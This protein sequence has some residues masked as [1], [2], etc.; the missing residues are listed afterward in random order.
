MSMDTKHPSYNLTIAPEEIKKYLEKK[1]VFI[2]TDDNDIE[3]LAAL[4][5]AEY[6]Y[7]LDQV[8]QERAKLLAVLCKILKYACVWNDYR[9]RIY[10]AKHDEK[11]LLWDKEWRNILL[12]E[13]DSILM[14]QQNIQLTWHFH[15]NDAHLLNEFTLKEDY[16]WDGHNT[17]EKYRNLLHCFGIK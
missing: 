15:D 13:L 1:G 10:R 6:K 11:D 5:I 8:Y 2:N 16:V 3:S 14:K 17:E 12:I 7:R 4:R 9:I